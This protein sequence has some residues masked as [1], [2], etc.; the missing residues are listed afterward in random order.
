M[1]KLVIDNNIS[2]KNLF[3]KGLQISLSVPVNPFFSLSYT[4]AHR[5]L[6]RIQNLS[7][8]LREHACIWELSLLIWGGDPILKAEDVYRDVCSQYGVEE[9]DPL[10]L[11]K[12]KR[13]DYEISENNFS[14]LETTVDQIG[15]MPIA[16]NAYFRIIKEEI[17][18][19]EGGLF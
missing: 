3:S 18:I 19:F 17:S 10:S 8:D 16:E 9:T 2:L 1:S 4:S 5:F 14:L 6:A 7:K 12:I 13:I 15:I 11:A